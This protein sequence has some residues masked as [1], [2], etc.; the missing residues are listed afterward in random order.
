MM[1]TNDSLQ[2]MSNETEN[3]LSCDQMLEKT[4][5][6]LNSITGAIVVFGNAVVFLSIVCT[7]RLRQQKV[8][9]F[10]ASLAIA[11]MI[12]GAFVAPGNATFCLGC[13][14]YTVSNYCWLLEFPKDVVLAG[15]ITNLFAISFDRYLA[16]FRPLQYENVMTRRRCV[17]TLIAVWSVSVSTAVVRSILYL[18]ITGPEITAVNGVYNS[19]LMAVVL[20]TPSILVSIIN[21]KIII[22]IRVQGRQVAVMRNPQDVS[23]A[24]NLEEIR[25]EASRKRKGTIACALV[26]IIFV[27][28][29]IP[30][31]SF[32]I[33]YL[34][35]GDTHEI[36]ALLQ[37]LSMFFLLMQSS[38]NPFIYSFY[39]ADF[40]Q[41]VARL[42]RFGT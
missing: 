16:V 10:L 38:V 20:V 23:E 40:R 17:N 29:W 35:S 21:I 2:P 9:L 26:V 19:I 14:Q 37:K 22:A 3:H 39:R 5:I 4:F 18:T 25:A 27:V 24:E 11:D 8:N 12:M 6:I 13:R 34:V 33:Q 42:L 15:S 32:N 28:S 1:F 41:A 36:D 7:S 30:R 31:I